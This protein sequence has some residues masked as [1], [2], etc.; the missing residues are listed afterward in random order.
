[1]TP[2]E[3]VRAIF[4]LQEERHPD[5][6]PGD[7]EISVQDDSA[8]RAVIQNGQIIGAGASIQEALEAAWAAIQ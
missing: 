5:D 1:M 3:L 8:L 7:L 2:D 4:K 6:D